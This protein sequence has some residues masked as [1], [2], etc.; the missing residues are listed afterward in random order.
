MTTLTLRLIFPSNQPIPA[1]ETSNLMT[2][3]EFSV[4]IQETAGNQILIRKEFDNTDDQ[5][6]DWLEAIRKQFKL[7]HW[8]LL[9]FVANNETYP[10]RKF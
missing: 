10:I 7:I 9:S 6:L 4:K 3:H 5:F 1:I 2:C 8:E